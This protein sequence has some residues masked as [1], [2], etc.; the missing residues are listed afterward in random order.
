MAQPRVF[1]S[2]KAPAAQPRPGLGRVAG[3]DLN[4]LSCLLLPFR[5]DPFFRL[6]PAL[7]H[8]AMALS[9]ELAALSYHLELDEWL[10][11]GW[12]DCSIQID[13]TLQS[14][15]VRGE[16]ASGEQMRSLLN[17]WK[18][19]RARVSLRERNP[20]MRIAGA[21]RQRERSDTIK[22]V[23]MLHKQA[24]GRY[25]VAIGFM[26]TGSRFYDWFSNFRFITEE[27]F[28][29]GFFQLTAYFEQSAE[30]IVFPDTA[31]ELGLERLTLADIFQEMRSANSRFFLWMAGHSQGAA[32][33]QILC[34]RLLTDWGA[35]PQ[36]MVGYGF[37]SPTVATGQFVYDPALYPLY[38]V[39]NSDDVVP[40]IG[41]LLHLGLCLEYQAHDSF[42]QDVYAL[43]A[44][45]GIVSA[46]EA[47]E[48]FIVQMTDTLSI[49]E[50]SV[51]FC[52]C[53][54]EE[55]GEENLS[56]LIDKKWTVAPIE[57]MLSYA[58]DKAQDVV[59]AIAQ[60]A[61]KGY[62][63]LAGHGMDQERIDRLKERMRPA[64][65]QHTLRQLLGGLSEL[66]G[67]P[68]GI[69]REHFKFT[70]A[71]SYIVQRGWSAL[72]P[73][74]W[75]KQPQALPCRAYGES[76]SWAQAGQTLPFPGRRLPAKRRRR[77]PG[78]LAPKGVRSR[79]LRARR[80]RQGR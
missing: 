25:I 41:A 38:H 30:R 24:P 69:M 42:R 12:T 57:R 27:G 21:L 73:F 36:N 13:N 52:Y 78:A 58:G 65:K 1:T 17:S 51:A 14:G 29:K 76:L 46:R 5:Q 72:K 2:R 43:S 31:A 44:A 67:A 7:S 37:A 54:L 6:R 77:H 4:V 9:L 70:G 40:R 56:Q 59:R 32:V 80:L 53:L 23:T 45:P 3:C 62:I 8:E 47:L 26:G 34:H 75:V 11:A 39:L 71:Y 20:I 22:A 50:S 48:P 19:Y 18:L 16:S 60:Y 66:T 15:V 63:S 10:Q 74:I 28:H 61:Q 33:M 64:V 68:H 79:S 55:K 49:M 35:L